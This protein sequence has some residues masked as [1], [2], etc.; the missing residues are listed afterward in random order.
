M[1][2]HGPHLLSEIHLKIFSFLQLIPMDKSARAVVSPRRII[3]INE[4]LSIN[5]EVYWVRHLHPK[6]LSDFGSLRPQ[7][8][9]LRFRLGR[10]LGLMT[11][12]TVSGF[13]SSPWM[14]F[15][16]VNDLRAVLSE[17]RSRSPG[18]AMTVVVEEYTVLLTRNRSKPVGDPQMPKQTM[19]RVVSLDLSG[20]QPKA[21]NF[22]TLKGF[23][24]P[25]RKIC[26]R[27]HPC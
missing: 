2:F 27:S 10:K 26:W 25:S 17:K 19:V 12:A 3:W 7:V 20:L 24:N 22:G 8:L 13:R 1:L 9:W 11:S 5:L 15:L 21:T 14:S 16:L 6:T 18:A 4:K 23:K